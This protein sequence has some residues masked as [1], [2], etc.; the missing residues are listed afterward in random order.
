MTINTT[1]QKPYVNSTKLGAKLDLTPYEIKALG[2]Q[3]NAWKAYGR[4]EMIRN[5]AN[6]TF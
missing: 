6:R 3:P 5:N 1:G 4:L 2:P